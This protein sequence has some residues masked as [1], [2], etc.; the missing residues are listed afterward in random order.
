MYVVQLVHL[1]PAD[2]VAREIFHS[3][4][5]HQLT[6]IVNDGHSPHTLLLKKLAHF[7]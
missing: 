2:E 1:Q 7:Q 5:A 6:L 3:C 4:D